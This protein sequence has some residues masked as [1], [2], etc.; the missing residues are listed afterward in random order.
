MTLILQIAAGIILAQ[1]VFS[2]S[3]AVFATLRG[4]RTVSDDRIKNYINSLND[5]VSSSYES[6][7]IEEKETRSEPALD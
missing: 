4:R 6:V 5:L 2:L 1:I 3:V 7:E